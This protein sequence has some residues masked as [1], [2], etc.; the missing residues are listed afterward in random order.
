LI[1]FSK[2]TAYRNSQGARSVD[3]ANEARVPST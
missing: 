2:Q 1:S 3:P